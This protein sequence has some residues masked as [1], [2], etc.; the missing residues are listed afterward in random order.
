MAPYGS[1]SARGSRPCREVAVTL[2]PIYVE[3]FVEGDLDDLWR[4]TQDPDE[5]ERWDPRF[6]EISY[7]PR[8]D[9]EPQRFTYATRLGGRF[10]PGIEG[11]G[12][13]V[14]TRDDGGETTS[15]LAFDS[16]SPLSPIR[17]G[18]GFWR[19]VET[20]DGVRFL[21][22]YSYEAPWGRAGRFLDGLVVRPLLGWATALGFDVL[23]RWIEDGT[24]PEAS[25]RALLAHAVARIGLALVWI[26]QGLVPKLFVS[27]P[28][29]RGPFEAVGLD[30]VAVEAVLVLGLLEV[31]LGIALLVRWRS[32]WLAYAA[33]LAPSVLV[34]GTLLADPSPALGP[35]N[36]VT[37]AVT[38]AALG[39]V[40]GSHAGTLPSAANCLREPPAGASS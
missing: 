21:T 9:D 3:R 37:L 23:G 10:G 11:T 27:H 38:M 15:V 31:A 7:L 17:D 30:A 25:Y 5:H 20:D 13:S 1:R 16:D 35:F 36:P 32:A 6:T 26:Y 2:D 12:E 33:G 22:E 28:D 39:I 40:A 8:A 4:L 24:P 19:Y 34:A 18:R 14:A 29:E